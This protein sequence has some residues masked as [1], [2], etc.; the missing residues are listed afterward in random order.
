MSLEIN[1]INE[2]TNKVE[3]VQK[4]APDRMF[5]AVNKGIKTAKEIA[6]D[7]T[8]VGPDKKPEKKRM[9]NQWVAQQAKYDG[10]SWEAGLYN[11]APH[12]HLVNNG[13]N[14]VIKDRN[15]RQ[16]TVGYVP[17]LKFVEKT[18]EEAET[19]AKEDFDKYIEEVFEGLIE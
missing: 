3:V 15:G 19:K 1:G 2:L 11:K 14:Q 17:G 13:H 8:P 16:K 18:V 12:K 4:K 7:N 9:Q 10:R 6:K 5:D